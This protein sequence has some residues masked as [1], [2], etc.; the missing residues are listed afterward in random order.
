MTTRPNFTISVELEWDDEARADVDGERVPTDAALIR[1][2]AA[3]LH[4]AGAGGGEQLEV[5]VTIV[6]LERMG[7]VNDEHRGLEGA[8]DVLAFPIDGLLE[9]I[10]PGEPRVVGDLVICPAYVLRQL[11]EGTTMA[12]HGPGQE[13]GD[14]TLAAALERCVVHGTLHLAGFDHERG[15]LEAREQFELEQL[16]LDRVRGARDRAE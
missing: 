14:A 9:P 5:G 1:L 7:A 11:A 15:E 16:V 3:A 4:E 8:T 6:G 2:V 12:P 10:E 13:D